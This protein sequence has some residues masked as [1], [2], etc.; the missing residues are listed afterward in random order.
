MTTTLGYG[1]DVSG[2]DDYLPGGSNYSP[3]YSQ[4]APLRELP[5]CPPIPEGLLL[6]PP[7]DAPPGLLQENT[8]P[9]G[10]IPS[11]SHL[12]ESPRGDILPLE[13]SCSSSGTCKGQVACGSRCC[14]FKWPY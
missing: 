14:R 13:R 2:F 9:G 3:G 1:T 6:G 5:V 4:P 7:S 10:P 11:D 12:N 8:S